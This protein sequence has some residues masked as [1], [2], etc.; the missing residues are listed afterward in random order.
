MDTETIKE[1]LNLHV[2][3]RLQSTESN[4]KAF[5]LNG[6]PSAT[7]STNIQCS[8]NGHSS[9]SGGGSGGNTPGTK[10]ARSPKKGRI[11]KRQINSSTES[12]NLP[13][14]PTMLPS[15]ALI[16]TPLASTHTLPPNN[17]NDGEHSDLFNTDSRQSDKNLDILTL[18]LNEKKRQLMEDPEVVSFLNNIIK[19]YT[20]TSKPNK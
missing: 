18:V 5:K 17:N 4:E 11:S 8:P 14:T 13:T 3:R 1:R 20:S 19:L 9:C 16:T 6:T 10:S 15:S 7:I 12:I 2:K